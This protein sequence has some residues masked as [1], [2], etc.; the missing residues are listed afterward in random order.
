[1]ERAV[2]IGVFEY[3]GF[4]LCKRILEEGIEVDAVH[5]SQERHPMAEQR[6]L[7]IGRN[8]NFV[9]WDV[10]KF[11]SSTVESGK[12]IVFMDLMTENKREVAL[13]SENK[14]RLDEMLK[15]LSRKNGRVV[16][17]L[18]FEL[19]SSE[20]PLHSNFQRLMDDINMRHLSVKTFYLP[21]LNESTESEDK[22]LLDALLEIATS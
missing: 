9:E 19:F 15:Q 4:L 14:D 16:F 12:T 21:A 22:D 13:T 1:M 7:E 8:A 17:F 6:R 3:L 20:S 18:P 2:I 11:N 10:E 5:L